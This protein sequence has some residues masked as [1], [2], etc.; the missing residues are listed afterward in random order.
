[1]T[2]PAA[3]IEGGRG[4]RRKKEGEGGGERRRERVEVSDHRGFS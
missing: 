4:W 3:E 1:M 2:T